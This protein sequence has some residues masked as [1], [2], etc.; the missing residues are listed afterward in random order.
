M[1]LLE[2]VAASANEGTPKTG[3]LVR[4]TELVVLN[5]LI[6]SSKEFVMS[7]SFHWLRPEPEGLYCGWW[8]IA[9]VVI[10]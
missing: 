1:D 3:K 4:P 2:I 9:T 5:I 10:C 7:Q 8:I 6:R